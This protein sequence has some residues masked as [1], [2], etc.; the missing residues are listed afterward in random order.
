MCSYHS[1]L[2]VQ[3]LGI[4][5]DWHFL[6]QFLFYFGAGQSL[7]TRRLRPQSGPISH[8]LKHQIL[9]GIFV[10]RRHTMHCSA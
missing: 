3:V 8:P 5:F 10:V 9:I 1:A 2:V 4:L 6:F 7:P